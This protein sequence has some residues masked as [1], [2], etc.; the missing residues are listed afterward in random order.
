MMDHNNRCWG[1]KGL[2][3]DDNICISNHKIG[4]RCFTCGNNGH[5]EINHPFV[6]KSIDNNYYY[7]TKCP[8]C[9]EQ[10]TYAGSMVDFS[11]IASG[12]YYASDKYIEIMKQ[13][14]CPGSYIE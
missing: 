13:H 11:G 5:L 12:M 3:E 2:I 4:F 8:V 9:G 7:L 1:C 14:G 10:I 6:S